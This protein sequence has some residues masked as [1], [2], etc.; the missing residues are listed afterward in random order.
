M[1]GIEI[2]QALQQHAE[3]LICEHCKQEY[4]T[5]PDIEG[6]AGLKRASITH[7]GVK[8]YYYRDR[9]HCTPCGICSTPTQKETLYHPLGDAPICERCYLSFKDTE[10]DYLFEEDLGEEDLESS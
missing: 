6:M 10:S 1:T 8:F 4:G 9:V 2:T 5:I 7:N 3:I